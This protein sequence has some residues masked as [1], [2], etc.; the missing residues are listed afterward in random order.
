MI[1]LIIG[2]ISPIKFYNNPLFFLS[3][4]CIVCHWNT[5]LIV[6]NYAKKELTGVDMSKDQFNGVWISTQ[7]QNR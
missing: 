5:P 7:K 3:V 2:I 6:V 4:I 1:S